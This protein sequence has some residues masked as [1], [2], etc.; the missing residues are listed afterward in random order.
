MPC[1]RATLSARRRKAFRRPDGV[2]GLRG[3][4]AQGNSVDLRREGIERPSM[5]RAGQK[6]TAAAGGRGGDVDHLHPGWVSYW[7]S[8]SSL[9]SRAS[10]FCGVS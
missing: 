10:I 9:S 2:R 3:T 4:G 7:R 6:K 8:S 1:S 5:P